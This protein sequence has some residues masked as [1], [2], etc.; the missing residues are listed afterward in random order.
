MLRYA[1]ANLYPDKASM[2]RILAQADIED[3]RIRLGDSPVN[4]WAAIITEAQAQG[5]L[6]A[7]IQQSVSEY[8]QN[9][10]LIEA[11]EAWLRRDR[12][13]Q[14]TM[15]TD[16]TPSGNGYNLRDTIYEIRDEIKENR[17]INMEFQIDMSRRLVTLNAR[18]SE[19]DAKIVPQKDFMHA[20]AQLEARVYEEVDRRALRWAIVV[21][22]I[23]V[24]V[25]MVLLYL[26]GRLPGPLL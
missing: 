16:Y 15:P 13:K 9:E 8:P 11:I 20:I 23:L 3:E 26:S 17:R 4:D 21:A 7:I 5:R 19:L 24:I 1:L 10:Q 12:T 22:L 25:F 6:Y 14:T 18:V 2:R